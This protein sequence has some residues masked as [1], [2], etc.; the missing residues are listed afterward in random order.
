M[1][2]QALID[3]F[4]EN[5]WLER[6]LSD[7]TLKSYRYDLKQFCNWLDSQNNDLIHVSHGDLQTYLA[8][9]YQQQLKSSSTS[10]MLSCL[11]KFYAFLSKTHQITDNPMTLI[12]NPKLQ[13]GL[14]KSISEQQID[15]LL[16]AP[17]TNDAIGLR[18]R[19]MLETLYA[20]GLR[21]SEL[22]GLTF[23]QVS[24]NQGLTRIMGKGSKERLTPLGEEAVFWIQEYINKARPE[25][26]GRQVSDYLFLSRR[27]SN[28][29]R[30]TFWY[31]LKAMAKQ[32]GIASNITPHTLRHAFATH[33]LNHGADLRAVQMLLGH[34]DLSTTQIY[35]HIAQHRL[36][37][38]HKKHHPRG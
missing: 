26:L 7:N 25:L 30:Q 37:E 32:S 6:G 35:T 14:P 18:D 12:E 9:R 3:Q 23:S 28:M 19:A 17:D 24:L 2:N 5:Q 27:G 33:L 21:V 8:F 31:R 4:I 38:L 1:D 13:R 15:L 22:V 20:S 34:S 29:T 36:S 10:R 11:R 16:Q